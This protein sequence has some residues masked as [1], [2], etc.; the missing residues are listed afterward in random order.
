MYGV[1]K[2]NGAEVELGWIKRY[3][4]HTDPQNERCV[5]RLYV[6]ALVEL[7]HS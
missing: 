2:V 3:I 7:S 6:V 4:T 1:I 5:C